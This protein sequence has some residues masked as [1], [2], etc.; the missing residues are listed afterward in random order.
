MLQTQYQHHQAHEQTHEQAQARLEI[1]F[2]NIYSEFN[3][4]QWECLK[5]NNMI[6]FTNKFAPLDKFYIETSENSIYEINVSIPVNKVNYKNTIMNMNEAVSYIKMHIAFYELR[7][8][9]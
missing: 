5:T 1:I 3:E 4:N 2:T 9:L 7:S 6:T 8:R